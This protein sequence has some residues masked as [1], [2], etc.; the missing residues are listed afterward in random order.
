MYANT[1]MGEWSESKT[2]ARP[3]ADVLQNRFS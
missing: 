1:N 2:Q 3:F